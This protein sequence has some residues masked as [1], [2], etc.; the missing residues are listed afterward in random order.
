MGIRIFVYLSPSWREGEITMSLFNRNKLEMAAI[1]YRFIV[2][3]VEMPEVN[4]ASAIT[5]SVHRIE[6]I[7]R[8]PV[9]FQE[10]VKEQWCLDGLPK[11]KVKHLDEPEFITGGS[12]PIRWTVTF[13]Y[14]SAPVHHGMN[15]FQQI[16]LVVTIWS[17]IGLLALGLF[18][19]SLAAKHE[20]EQC[21]IQY[22]DN[23]PHS[24][25]VGSS[26]YK[27]NTDGTMP[28]DVRVHLNPYHSEVINSGNCHKVNL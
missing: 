28:M 23:V 8:N 13:T 15:W 6:A 16:I 27:L 11:V 9:P 26:E 24:L 4:A 10:E 1:R 2:D 3:G 22:M 17:V 12:I 18:W 5:D 20:P 25:V 14:D 19:G 7:E 21:T